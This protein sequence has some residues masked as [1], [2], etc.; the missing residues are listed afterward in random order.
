MSYPR[1]KV[2]TMLRTVTFVDSEA[3]AR[4]L[5]LMAVLALP[6]VRCDEGT[7][8]KRPLVEIE[9]HT[10]VWRP[11]ET[12]IVLDTLIVLSFGKNGSTRTYRF[13]TAD[14]PAWRMP[15]KGRR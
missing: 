11:V 5:G 15:S 10:G 1:V 8:T 6:P 4:L 12:I 13:L 14:C 2:P 3:H 7:T 9:V